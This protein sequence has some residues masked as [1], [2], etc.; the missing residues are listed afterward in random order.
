MDYLYNIVHCW[1]YVYGVGDDRI[2]IVLSVVVVWVFPFVLCCE[3]SG[4][5][6]GFNP[7]T[8]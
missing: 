3:A 2:L 6:I 7:Q 8:V 4:I 5:I 1:L